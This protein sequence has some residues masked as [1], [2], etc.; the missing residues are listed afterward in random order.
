MIRILLLASVFL[1]CFLIFW[2]ASRSS[3]MKLKVDLFCIAN[4]GF[5]F[6]CLAGVYTYMADEKIGFFVAIASIAII[7][8]RKYFYGR[9]I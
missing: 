1:A 3:K 2:I 6:A 4:I 8:L 7:A 5:C 9:W